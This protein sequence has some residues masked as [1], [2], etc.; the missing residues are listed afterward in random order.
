MERHAKLISICTIIATW[1]IYVAD[2]AINIFNMFGDSFWQSLIGIAA[3]KVYYATFVLFLFPILSCSSLLLSKPLKSRTLGVLMA[4]TF[5][6]VCIYMHS[7][8]F[9]FAKTAALYATA[10]H[11]TKQ[12]LRDLLKHF[13]SIKDIF[14]VIFM[15]A[16]LVIFARIFIRVISGRTEFP[17]YF[18]FINPVTGLLVSI[19]LRTIAPGAREAIMP[20]FVSSFWLGLLMTSYLLYWLRLRSSRR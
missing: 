11:P 20:V 19:L 12:T 7:I 15:A 9:P 17:R 13:T 1:V 16:F 2:L 5:S 6:T 8:Y 18:A 4:V 3:W 14:G 10:D